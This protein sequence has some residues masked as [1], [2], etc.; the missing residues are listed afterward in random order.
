MIKITF[1]CYGNICRS[2]LAEFLFRD[3][4]GEKGKSEKFLVRSKATSSEELG[5]PVY[6]PVK[7]ILDRMGIDC[8]QKRAEKLRSEDYAFSDLFIGMDGRNVRDMQRIFGGDPQNKVSLLLD[9][10]DRPGSVADPWY[11]GNFDATW[12]DVNEGCTG[13]LAFLKETYDL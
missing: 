8:S 1:V 10:T 2:P 3:L 13:L 11:T 12:K 6:P 5:N 9:Y 4:L 7:R